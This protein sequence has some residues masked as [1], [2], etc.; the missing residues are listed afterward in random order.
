MQ[1][2][3]SVSCQFNDDHQYIVRS[4]AYT[5]D[6]WRDPRGTTSLK[7]AVSACARMRVPGRPPGFVP[8]QLDRYG[9]AFGSRLQCAESERSTGKLHHAPRYETEQVR[10]PRDHR[11]LEDLRD[12]E[13]VIELETLPLPYAG[14]RMLAL[15]APTQRYKAT[16]FISLSDCSS[17]ARGARSAPPPRSVLKERVF[18]ELARFRQEPVHRRVNPPFRIARLSSIGRDRV[19]KQTST[20]GA[21]RT[22]RSSSQ[23][24]IIGPSGSNADEQLSLRC[25]RIEGPPFGDRIAQS[26]ARHANSHRPCPLPAGQHSSQLTGEQLSRNTDAA[27][28]AR[29]LPP[30]ASSTAVPR[31]ETGFAPHKPLRTPAGG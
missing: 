8:H 14:H 1:L 29:D 6:D 23:T 18:A 26:P 4:P 16:F 9:Y 7:Q 21:A 20:P 13:D 30:T 17:A 10:L 27:A 12:F 25:L 5:P 11:H 2:S 15:D 31:R 19:L 22:S 28:T 3:P 24:A